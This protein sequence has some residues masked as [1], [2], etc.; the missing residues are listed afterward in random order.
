[1]T[2]KVLIPL[3]GSIFQFTMAG[4]IDNSTGLKISV[5]PNDVT[6][7]I[8]RLVVNKNNIKYKWKS[9][10]VDRSDCNLKVIGTDYKANLNINEEEIIKQKGICRGLISLLA[11]E[12][13]R[14]NYKH[15][16]FSDRKIRGDEKITLFLINSHFIKERLKFEL[17]NYLRALEDKNRFNPEFSN[18]VIKD[19]KKYLISVGDDILL[20]VVKDSN[21]IY[22]RICQLLVYE[23]TSPKLKNQRT[24]NIF[25][26]G[27]ETSIVSEKKLDEFYKYYFHDALIRFHPKTLQ[28]STGKFILNKKQIKQL[29]KEFNEYHQ[30][31]DGNNI[32]EIL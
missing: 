31:E 26:K 19:G 11:F 4:G 10:K 3:L 18:K 8:R 1:M 7:D 17:E 30:L 16:L 24:L 32:L 22:R 14:T 28:N 25:G 9:H 21:N 20:G 27:N 12:V 2:K 15:F 5:Y 13:D 6:L 29:T 23:N